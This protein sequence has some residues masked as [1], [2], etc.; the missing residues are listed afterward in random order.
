[1]SERSEQ[2]KMA[3]FISE[4]LAGRGFKTE[5][6]A[7]EKGWILLRLGDRAVGVDEG[8]G[9][10]LKESDKDEWRRICESGMIGAALEAVE[11]LIKG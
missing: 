8:S 4:T 10:W 5:S 1:M 3:G 11:F 2:E 6:M 7:S 9:I